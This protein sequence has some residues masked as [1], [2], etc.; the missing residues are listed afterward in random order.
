MIIICIKI[1]TT[2]FYDAV[3]SYVHF[4]IHLRQAISET[5][6]IWTEL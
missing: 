6:S 1:I 3:R 5:T 4:H 2:L